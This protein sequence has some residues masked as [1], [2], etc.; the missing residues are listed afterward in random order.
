MK[1]DLG[2]AL[3]IAGIPLLI[4]LAVYA[5]IFGCAP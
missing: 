5:R 2:E 1:S 4:A 3:Y